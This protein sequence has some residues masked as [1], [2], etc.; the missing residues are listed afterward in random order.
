MGRK[1]SNQTNKQPNM[2]TMCII[3]RCHFI[4][5]VDEKSVDPDQLASLE[6]S[7][8]RSTL[9]SRGYRTYKKVGHIVCIVGLI[10]SIKY[11]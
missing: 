3:Q 6:A 2:Y 1:G 4:I 9:F 8:S 10:Q 5:I 11:S 7:L